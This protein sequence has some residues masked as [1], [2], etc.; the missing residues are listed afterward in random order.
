MRTFLGHMKMKHFLHSQQRRCTVTAAITKCSRNVDNVLN[1]VASRPASLASSIAH[2]PACVE[3]AMCSMTT[4][5]FNAL[6][7]VRFLLFF[8][9][10]FFLRKVS[11]VA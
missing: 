11:S 10:T 6:I 8:E 5:A 2:L 4:F 3:T 1:V 7:A 9:F